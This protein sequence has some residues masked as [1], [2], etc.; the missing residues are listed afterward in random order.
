MV[1]EVNHTFITLVPYE[2]VMD[3]GKNNGDPRACLKMDLQ[4]AYDSVDRKFL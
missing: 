4:K 3:Y 1:C 2:L